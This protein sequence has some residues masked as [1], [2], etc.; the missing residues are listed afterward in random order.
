MFSS[1]SRDTHEIQTAIL[2][3][4]ASY[5]NCFGHYIK[6][7]MRNAMDIATL[8]ALLHAGQP[9]V[10]AEH[11]RQGRPHVHHLLHGLAVDGAADQFVLDA[12][13]L[14]TRPPSSAGSARRD[15]L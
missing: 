6:Y 5:E 7:A 14:W 12:H 10:V 9:E 2:I 3:P 13:A 1:S 11:V 8:A 15:S 4:K